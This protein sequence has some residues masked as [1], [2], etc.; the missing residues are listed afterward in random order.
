MN[1]LAGE[2]IS[3]KEDP[4]CTFIEKSPS[5][6]VFAFRIYV[7][8]VINHMTGGGRGQG[9]GGSSWDADS[10]NYPGVPFGPNDFNCCGC[11]GCSTNDCTIKNYN[12]ANQ[13]HREIS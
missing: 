1:T 2:T 8:A 7:D 6:A 12:D 5:L 9:S 4:H 11:S 13:V 3:Y 10:L